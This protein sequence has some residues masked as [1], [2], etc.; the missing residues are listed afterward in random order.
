MKI[1][2]VYSTDENY[3]RYCATSILSLLE[4]STDIGKI[5]IIDNK[6]KIESKKKLNDMISRFNV[7]IVYIPID[8]IVYDLEKN[9]DF[10]ISSYARLLMQREI[11]EDKIIYI[12]CDT[13]VVDNIA[14]LWNINI[15]DYWVAGVQDALPKILKKK[16]GLKK[17][18]R[19]INAR[20]LLINLKKWKE[21]NLD[22]RYINFVNEHKGNVVH[23]DQ[24]LIN[25]VCKNKIYI[26]PPEY[27]FM[28]EMTY[29]TAK[30][31]KKLYSEKNYYTQKELDNAKSLPVIIHFISKFYKRPWIEGSTNPYTTLFLQYMKRTG[32]DTKLLK[33]IPNKKVELRKKMYKKL[34]FFLYM[35]FE[36]MLDFKRNI[37]IIIKYR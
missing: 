31:L 8:S 12:D 23:H 37:V 32:F 33:D 35:C 11:V 19:Y 20:V 5:Y 28:S 26:L 25:G 4:N 18:D 6:I 7:N 36:K 3:V 9:N 15:E 13:I 30:Q 24:G 16:V 22:K 10:S 34:P 2:V 29:Y 27:N 21:E 1:S 14:K 17:E